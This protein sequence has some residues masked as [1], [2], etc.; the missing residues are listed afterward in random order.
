MLTSS[1]PQHEE[2]TPT[3]R[4]EP[5]CRP[6]SNAI[7]HRPSHVLPLVQDLK[8]NPTSRSVLESSPSLQSLRFPGPAL[9]LQ[10]LDGLEENE[11]AALNCA[12]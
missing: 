5:I 4:C 9:P 1:K 7:L 10:D 11:R 2:L 12:L 6:Y 8:Q 3:P